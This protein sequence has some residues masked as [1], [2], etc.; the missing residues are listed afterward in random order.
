MNE[1]KKCPNCGAEVMGVEYSII[2]QEHYDGVSEYMCA[3]ECGWRIG[4]WSGIELEEDEIEGRYG[5]NS[6]VKIKKDE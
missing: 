4:R 1:I 5:E 2:S 6:P 3:K